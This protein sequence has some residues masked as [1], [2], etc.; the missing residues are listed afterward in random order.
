MMILTSERRRGG[1]K[2]QL[3]VVRVILN[4]LQLFLLLFDSNG[5]S[6]NVLAMMLIVRLG[7][8]RFN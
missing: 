2:C 6:D 8:S 7:R 1:G 4:V 5:E 3:R